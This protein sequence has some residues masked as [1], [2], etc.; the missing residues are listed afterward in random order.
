MPEVEDFQLPATSRK[1]AKAAGAKTF[2]TGKPCIGGHVSERL[3]K[4]GRCVRCAIE[5][6]RRFYSRFKAVKT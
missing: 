5:A 3:T 4:S 6:D 1:E 2:S